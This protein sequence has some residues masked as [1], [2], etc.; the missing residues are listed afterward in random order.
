MVTPMRRGRAVTA[1]FDVDRAAVFHAGVDSD[2]RHRFTQVPA[3][4]QRLTDLDR[5]STLNT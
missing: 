2:A 3:M 4:A 5:D 1:K